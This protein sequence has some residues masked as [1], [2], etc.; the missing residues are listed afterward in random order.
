MRDD[1]S[2]DSQVQE[3]SDHSETLS[4]RVSEQDG[5]ES[6][7]RRRLSHS[8]VEPITATCSKDTCAEEEVSGGEDDGH[9][10]NP[11]ASP[12]EDNRAEGVTPGNRPMGEHSRL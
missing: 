7:P 5:G 11:D 6:E 1:A 12:G 4:K 10:A 3:S 8:Q 2:T 9:E